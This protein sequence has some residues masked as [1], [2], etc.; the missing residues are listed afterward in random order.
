MKRFVRLGVV[1]SLCTAPALVH[2]QSPWGDDRGGVWRGSFL[3]ETHRTASRF[4]EEPSAEDHAEESLPSPSDRAGGAAVSGP[5]A[6]T[7]YATSPYLMNDPTSGYGVPQSVY[8]SSVNS[9]YGDTTGACVDGSC[10]TGQC[11]TGACPIGSPCACS[12]WFGGIYGLVLTR[13]DDF[14]TYLSYESGM[15]SMPVMKTTDAATEF[16]GGFETRLGRYLNDCWGVEAV[17]WGFFPDDE[18]AVAQ[19]AWYAGDLASAIRYD[20]LSY[21]NGTTAGPLVDW[22]GSPM[23]PSAMH[24]LQRSFEAH[25]IEINFIRNPY[26]R[27]GCVHFELLAGFR[28]LNL[29]DRLR[30][31]SYYANTMYGDD[32]NDELHHIIDVENHLIGFQIGG[33]ADRYFWNCFGVHIGS[34]LGIY[35]N[36]VQHRQK[37][38]GGNGLAYVT[39]TGE[40][41][42]I[43]SDKDHVA[44]VGE[45][46]AGVSYDIGPCWRLTGGYRAISACGVG[47]ATSQFPREREF[48]NLVRSGQIDTS[49]CLLL[50]GAYF[51]VEYNW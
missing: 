15:P 13:D 1:L 51:G 28:Y 30:F 21:H 37:I 39:A 35:N 6:T 32:P 18:Y 45:L 24:E 19:N 9:F 41:Y 2:A 17:Y 49:D 14:D 8:G 22:Y 23:N 40:D 11:A 46:F 10:A 43:E 38:C 34:K 12:P 33:R 42:M 25:N 5:T 47:L 27:A 16:G 50:H 44:F 20:G 31:S 48:A 4:Q 29:D 26:R 36:H 3:P 7:P